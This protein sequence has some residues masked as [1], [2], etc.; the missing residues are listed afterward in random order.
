VSTDHDFPVKSPVG[1]RYDCDLGHE[2]RWDLLVILSGRDRAQSFRIARPIE[3]EVEQ[4]LA[5][6]PRWH[7]RCPDSRFDYD[8]FDIGRNNDAKRFVRGQKDE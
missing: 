8:W 7:C 2:E 1:V 6:E 4:H 3:N 5:A